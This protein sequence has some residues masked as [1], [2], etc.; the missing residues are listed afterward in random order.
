MEQPLASPASPVRVRWL[1]APGIGFLGLRF[2]MPEGP[3]GAPTGPWRKE[4]SGAPPGKSLQ[5]PDTEGRAGL[6]HLD[7]PGKALPEV[8]FEGRQKPGGGG[9]GGAG[10]P[11]G[12]L[13]PPDSLSEAEQITPCPSVVLQQTLTAKG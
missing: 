3:G 1:P 13:H 7:P 9:G 5:E 8:A 11:P 4:E 12:L 2:W 10:G 6:L